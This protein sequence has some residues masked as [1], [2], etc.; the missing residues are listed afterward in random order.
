MKH[1]CK[2]IGNKYPIL[3]KRNTIDI[4]KKTLITLEEIFPDP[5]HVHIF[6]S[7]SKFEKFAD[8]DNFH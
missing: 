8:I 2:V 1:L 4:V 7:Y 5:K 6:V 3:K